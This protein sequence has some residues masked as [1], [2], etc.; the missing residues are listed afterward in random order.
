MEPLDSVLALFEIMIDRDEIHENRLEAAEQILAYEAPDKPVAEAKAY[1]TEVITNRSL[2]ASLRLRAT[3]LMRKSEARRITRPPV[4]PIEDLE[5]RMERA[6]ER[7][8]RHRSAQK[9][10]S[11]VDQRANLHVEDH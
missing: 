2:A 3:K 5:G 10:D 9:E 11:E 4:Q 1:L 6:R 8:A 7:L